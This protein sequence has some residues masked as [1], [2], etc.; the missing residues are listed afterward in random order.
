MSKTNPMMIVGAVLTSKAP[1]DVTSPPES[2]DV[3]HWRVTVAEGRLVE[4]GPIF[5]Y[6]QVDQYDHR[7][8]FDKSAFDGA[9]KYIYFERESGA[10]RTALISAL[11]LSFQAELLYGL[12]VEGEYPHLSIDIEKHPRGEAYGTQTTH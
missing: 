9:Q 12:T 10:V 2:I 1:V 6:L 11:T 5:P 7:Q 3:H 4:D 8:T